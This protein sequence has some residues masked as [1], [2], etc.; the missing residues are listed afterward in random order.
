MDI[1]SSQTNSD[2]NREYKDTV[3]KLLF[4]EPANVVDLT[5]A[6]LKTSYE[7]GTEVKFVTH[8]KKIG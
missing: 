1:K 4:A 2:V 6:V 3:F 7:P 5:N 8:E